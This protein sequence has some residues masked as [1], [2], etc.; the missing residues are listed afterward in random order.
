MGDC[1]GGLKTFEYFKDRSDDRANRTQNSNR[2][3]R[4][5]LHARLA[6]Q[7]I[8]QEQHQD[9]VLEAVWQTAGLNEMLL[10]GGCAGES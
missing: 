1:T 3:D 9:H 7:H 6:A 4:H 2:Y 8:L 10:T 5:L